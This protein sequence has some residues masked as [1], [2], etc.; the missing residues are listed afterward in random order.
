MNTVQKLLEE[1]EEE[2]ATH[3]LMVEDIRDVSGDIEL[4]DW[5]EEFLDSIE[6]RLENGRNLSERQAETLEKIWN[7][8]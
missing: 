1:V 8:I 4:N 5:E 3:L 2:N 6:E 7:R